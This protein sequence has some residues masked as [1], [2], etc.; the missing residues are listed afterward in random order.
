MKNI[1]ISEAQKHTSPNQISLVCCEAPTGTTNLT[2]ISWWTYLANHPPMVGFAISKKSYS[3]ELI[4][5]NGMAILS[6]PGEAIADGAFQCGH[7]SGRDINKVDKFGIKLTEGSAKFP[8]HS[9]LAFECS[10]ENSVDAGDHTFFICNV[11]SIFYN[12]KE[13][14]LYSWNGYSRLAPL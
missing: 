14:Q 12:D 8:V 9:K 5:R 11:T 3:N 7:V 6:I 13:R 4:L 1:N 10:I 2:T